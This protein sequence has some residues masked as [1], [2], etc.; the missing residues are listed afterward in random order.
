[1]RHFGVL[2]IVAGLLA[3][4]GCGTDAPVTAP[5][6]TPKV[7][8]SAPTTGTTSATAS[9]STPSAVEF[10]VDG[11][12][13]YQL[14]AT[15]AQLQAAGSLA[16]VV[17]GGDACPQNTT[18]TGTGTWSEIHL[19]F[20]KDGK[21]Y[22]LINKSASI[23]TPSGAWLGTTQ[24]DLKKIY[25][26]VNGQDLT[27]GT[28]AAFLVTTLTGRGILFELNEVKQVTAMYAGDASFLRTNF[29]NGSNFC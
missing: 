6:T 22:L 10:S 14:G 17:T 26:A 15:L 11:A 5:P 29:Q 3:A 9:A 1:M 16:G 21:L 13:P 24:A 12:G 8:T 20:R 4:A 25:A 18:A 19:S 7:T 2:L 23:P 28:R 27:Q